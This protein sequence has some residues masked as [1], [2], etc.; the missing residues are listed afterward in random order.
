M[1]V[2]VDAYHYKFPD[3]T[4]SCAPE[5][6]QQENTTINNPR[7]IIEVLSPSTETYNRE[8]TFSFY[9]K[10]ASL[11][12]YVL[13]SSQQQAIE[14]FTREGDIWLY[15]LYKAGESAQLHSLM[16]SLPLADVY[17]DVPIDD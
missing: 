6:L 4:V 12:E 8:K 7:V 1:R 3:I 16:F 11:Q 10:I 2:K 15:R 13:V 17:A 5:D 14:I 9:Q